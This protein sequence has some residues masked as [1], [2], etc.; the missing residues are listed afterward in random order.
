MWE[1]AGLICF[2]LDAH[3]SVLPTKLLHST[4][5]RSS[6]LH[7]ALA[8]YRP[9]QKLPF[10]YL[11][12][13]PSQRPV[14]ACLLCRPSSS[15]HVSV[16]AFAPAELAN[17]ISQPN[18]LDGNKHGRAIS[19][20]LPSL[21]TS[22]TRLRHGTE[23]SMIVDTLNQV[24]F[25]GIHPHCLVLLSRSLHATSSSCNVQPSSLCQQGKCNLQG[26]WLRRLYNVCVFLL[27]TVCGLNNYPLRGDT[28]MLSWPDTDRSSVPLMETLKEAS[29][30]CR[31]CS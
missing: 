1:H 24:S 28:C 15:R 20:L 5:D 26:N 7:N 6:G 13:R 2:I 27:P 4:S 22:I 16:L 10:Y 21:I 18:A 14:S 23:F 31:R 3:R 25:Q 30:S 11:L 17:T 29:Q 9:R 8:L 12:R 19:L